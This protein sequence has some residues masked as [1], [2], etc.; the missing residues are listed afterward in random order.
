MT[1][2]NAVPDIVDKIAAALNL[3]VCNDNCLHL[4]TKISHQD[5]TL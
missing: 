1:D 2:S 3:K 4:L 5:H